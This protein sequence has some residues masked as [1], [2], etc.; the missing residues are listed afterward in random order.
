M[1][2]Y[3]LVHGGLHGGWCWERIV[4]LLEAAGHRADAPDLPG[5]GADRTP[6][7]EDP[8]AQWIEAMVA[9]V[10]AAPEPVIL[11]GHSQGGPVISQMAERIP[12]KVAGLVYVTAL[13]R[14]D[15]ETV[16]GGAPEAVAS[17]LPMDIYYD[18][19][20]LVMLPEAMARAAFYNLCSEADI[21]AALARLTPQPAGVSFAVLSLSEERFGR[22]AKYYVETR[23]DMAIPLDKQR[24]MQGNWPCTLLAT[25]DTDHSPFYTAPEELAAA[26]LSVA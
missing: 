1:A 16:L 14:C 4:P 15:G 7:A 25:L 18:E 23:H 9:R 2:H 22:I 12:E 3:I 8:F 6:F 26:L 21:V 11:V 17:D 20:G 24:E 5:M 10:A 19:N 13:L